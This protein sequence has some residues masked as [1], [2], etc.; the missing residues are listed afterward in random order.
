LQ[1]AFKNLKSIVDVIV[2]RINAKLSKV[3]LTGNI[4]CIGSSCQ[5]IPD[6][7][8]AT[9]SI[10]D[11]SRQDAPSITLASKKISNLAEFPISF[12]IE[13]EKALL[14]NKYGQYSIRA[15]I[16][17]DNTLFFTTDTQFSVLDE[18]NEPL[19]SIDFNVISVQQSLS[20]P[21]PTSR[22]IPG[23]LN[24]F[25]QADSLVKGYVNQVI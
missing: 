1:F 6:G 3:K 16:R 12:E 22:P 18:K 15:E 9:I 7:S 20:I 4:D 25:K 2:E 11:T 23:G 24:E 8:V 14:N 19:T 17:K 21:Q 13:Y 5:T 10:L